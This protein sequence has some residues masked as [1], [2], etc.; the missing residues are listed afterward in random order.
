MWS[1]TFLAIER[2]HFLRVGAWGAACLLVGTL[3]GALLAV[4]R[5]RSPLLYHFAAQTAL[6]GA[7]DVALAAVAIGRLRLP[8]YAA[9]TRFDRFLWFSV[10]IDA[11]GAAVGVT[12]AVAGWLLG[13]R[14][15]AVGAGVGVILQGV[16]LVA[17]DLVAI[18][19]VGSSV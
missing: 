11:G 17:L 19:Q 13:R 1:D 15:G 10:G 12:L 4:R 5:Q 16:A 3:L 6:W 9:A 8:D 2:A 18:A 14:L 7:I